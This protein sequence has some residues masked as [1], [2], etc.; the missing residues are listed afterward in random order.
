MEDDYLV[1]KGEK[2]MENL[3]KMFDLNRDGFITE[4]EIKKTMKNLGEKIKKKD[5]RKMMKVADLNKD[6]KI[7]FPGKSVTLLENPVKYMR[8]YQ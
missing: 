5:V 8:C 2:E 3:F 4:R 7:S 1:Q 6:G